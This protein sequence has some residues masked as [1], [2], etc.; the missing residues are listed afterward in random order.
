MHD[1]GLFGVAHDIDLIRP[2]VQRLDQ[3]RNTSGRSQSR[4][5]LAQTRQTR[6]G[7]AT[8]GGG[9][10]TNTDQMLANAAA[11]LIEGVPV[12]GGY[13]KRVREYNAGAVDQALAEF[14]QNP[15]PA[16]AAA[17]RPHRIGGL[18]QRPA[19]VAGRGAACERHEH[20]RKHRA[21]N[22]A[23][24]ELSCAYP[25][26]LPIAWFRRSTDIGTA[27]QRA[28][29]REA[30]F[31][32][33]LPVG[34]ASGRPD[35]GYS[36]RAATGKAPRASGLVAGTARP[37]GTFSEVAPRMTAKQ[38]N[39]MLEHLSHI[40]SKL[41]QVADDVGVIK[42][43]MTSLEYRMDDMERELVEVRV[44]MVELVK[45]RSDVVVVHRRL[46][47]VDQ[48]LDRIEKRL[49]AGSH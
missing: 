11:K 21:L 2:G 5:R 46:D 38:N 6:K 45:V 32:S 25:D 42:L 40:L 49:D 19:A 30:L 35:A 4:W 9:S 28:N 20:R 7:A 22:G 3:C 17:A 10:I 31:V 44:G 48:C 12:V 29:K 41:D 26:F 39:L 18:A 34:R 37:A 8:M 47:Q 43:R 33:P 27:V 15:Q 13:A 16:R 24:G 1:L 36:G 14:L 23:V